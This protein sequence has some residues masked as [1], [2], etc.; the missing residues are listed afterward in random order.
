MSKLK[1]GYGLDSNG[2]I[3]SDVSK[4]KIEPAFLSCIQQSVA[5]LKKLFPKHLH[6]VYLYGSVARG[7]A[8]IPSSDLD[9]IAMFRSEVTSEQMTALKQLAVELSERYRNLVR[10]VGITV[11]AYR[12]RVALIDIVCIGVPVIPRIRILQTYR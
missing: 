5:S 1:Q 12:G 7:D 2:Y 3:L 10:E 6:S 8:V 11:V 9:L 4:E